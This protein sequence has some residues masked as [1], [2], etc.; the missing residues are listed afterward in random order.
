M[1][2]I[3]DRTKVPINECHL[4]FLETMAELWPLTL[5]RKLAMDAGNVFDIKSVDERQAVVIEKATKLYTDLIKY[6][7]IYHL[8]FDQKSDAYRAKELEICKNDFVHWINAYVFAEDPRLPPI[9][10][11]SLM[12]MVLWPEQERILTEFDYCYRNR[13]SALVEKSRETGATWM[14]I[15]YGVY[16]FLF[17][18]GFK[19]TLASRQEKL[20][21]QLG[22]PDSLFSKVRHILYHLPKKMRPAT[23]EKEGGPNDGVLRIINPDNGNSIIG[24]AGDNIGRGGR[25]SMI[26]IDEAAFLEHPEAV[27][28]ALSLSTNCQV[29]V[30]TPN[31][32]NSFY[33]KRSGG[34]VKVFTLWWYHDPSKNPDWRTGKRPADNAWYKFLVNKYAHDKVAVARE[35]DIDYNASVDGIFIPAE[36]VRAAVNFPIAAKGERVAGYDVAAGGKNESVYQLRI[37]SVA[38]E[39]YVL[40]YKTS[41]EATWAC[42]DKGEQDRILALNYDA[43]GIGESVYG[44]LKTSERPIKYHVNAIHGG[45]KASETLI[46]SEGR[47]G[48]QKYMNK[49][50]E[51]WDNLRQRFKRT[52]EHLNNIAHYP[53]DQLISIPDDSLLLS[54]LSA[55][56]EKRTGTGKIGVES[57]EEMRRRGVESP[58]RADA[59]VYAFA[60]IDASQRVLDKFDYVESANQV[61]DFNIDDQRLRGEQYVSLIQTPDMTTHALV[62]LWQM[63]TK[64][65]LKVYAEVQQQNAQATDMIELLEIAACVQANPIKEWI[66]N[67]EMFNSVEDGRSAPWYLYKKAGVTLRQNFTNEY[68][69]SIMIVNKMFADNMIMV[70]PNCEK[71]IFQLILWQK[72]GGRPDDSMAFVLALCQL[73]TRL[74]IKKQLTDGHF[75]KQLYG[76]GASFSRSAK[77]EPSV[78]ESILLSTTGRE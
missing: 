55:P 8:V 29:D 33:R 12:P 59:L 32:M 24:E 67:D 74:R 77:P 5:E 11:R 52:F 47:A 17:Q 69:G 19:L 50:A 6:R 70:H 43:D 14:F 20:V 2:E 31:G 78:V 53:E 76:G 73:V 10:L 1:I 13:M 27:D 40:Q 35:V 37:G 26:M 61:V 44:L 30:S 48:N 51:M 36:W 54:Q 75:R 34:G 16:Q 58:D 28:R 49:R 23:F 62:C 22:N 66:A 21:D 60:E 25:S 65:L 68:R 63:G 7:A 45:A 42:I 71:L 15:A 64:P 9:G 57:K 72:K 39:P 46:D 4:N 18:P 3:K 38:M 41:A 56:K